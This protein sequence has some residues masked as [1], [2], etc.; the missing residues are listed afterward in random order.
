[1]VSILVS[2]CPAMSRC[3]NTKGKGDNGHGEPPAMPTI[4]GNVAARLSVFKV[5]S[6][7]FISLL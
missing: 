5:R 3:S 7:H 2:M 1:M 6:D 4:P